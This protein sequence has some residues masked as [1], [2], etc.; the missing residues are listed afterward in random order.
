MYNTNLIILIDSLTSRRPVHRSLPA[1]FRRRDFRC[2]TQ[3]I[4]HAKTRLPAISFQPWPLHDVTFFFYIY[5]VVLY[6][7]TH[8][9]RWVGGY[10]IWRQS[11][12]G[13]DDSGKRMKIKFYAKEDVFAC[14]MCVCVCVTVDD[15]PQFN[16]FDSDKNV[17]V[18]VITL[19]DKAYVISVCVCAFF[20]FWIYWKVT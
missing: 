11:S 8:T 17:C 7:Y 2:S 12:C 16:H 3:M 15:T 10:E 5:F 4:R 6:H 14:V 18:C 9:M 13:C 19:L 1:P 20:L